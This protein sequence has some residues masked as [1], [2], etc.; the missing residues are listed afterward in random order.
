MR[1]RTLVHTACIGT[2]FHILLFVDAPMSNSGTPV[3]CNLLSELPQSW[4][5]LIMLWI[6][7]YHS[8][9][10]ASITNDM[11]LVVELI[12]IQRSH[13]KWVAFPIGWRALVDCN[14]LTLSEKQSECSIVSMIFCSYVI[15]YIYHRSRKIGDGIF[16]ESFMLNCTCVPL[17]ITINSLLTWS[18]VIGVKSFALNL[19][20]CLT[21][22]T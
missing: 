6:S 11:A 5:F 17:F 16:H 14:S 18:A 2:Q 15:F 20:G 21:L 4:K 19:Y 9:E 13:L 10:W 7:C 1:F 12:N 3:N 22:F 8:L